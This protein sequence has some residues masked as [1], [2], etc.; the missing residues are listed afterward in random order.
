MI[1]PQP[2]ILQAPVHMSAVIDSLYI[3]CNLLEHVLV[4]ETKTPLLH[5]VNKKTNVNQ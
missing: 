5:I 4:G 3:Y 2:Y 1:D